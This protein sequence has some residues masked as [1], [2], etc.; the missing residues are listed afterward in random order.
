MKNQLRSPNG[1][2]Y[3]YL[4][5]PTPELW[6]LALP[7]RTQIVYTPDTAFILAKLCIRPGSKCI[8][9]G[10]GSGSFTHALARQ[11]A[12]TGKVYTFEFHEK[13]HEL[14]TVEF[15]SHG[16]HDIV[17]AQHRDVCA[18]GFDV[19]RGEPEAAFLDLPAPW[20][21]IPHLPSVFTRNRVARVCCFSPCI[22]QVLATHSALR[23]HGFANITTYD[24]YYRNWESRQVQMRSVDDAVARLLDI[25]TRIKEGRKKEPT[26]NQRKL[27]PEEG[28][29]LNWLVVGRGEK[30]LQTHTSFLTFGELMPLIDGTVSSTLADNAPVEPVDL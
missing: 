12:P 7:H 25:R 2:G 18:D 6:T 14:N 29:G 22:E 13:R 15:K 5:R 27:K 10:T 16:L 20:E 1:S 30:D 17:T 23:K 4:L 26:E 9:A 24:L 28:D 19:P 8:E 21:A 3:I 11:V